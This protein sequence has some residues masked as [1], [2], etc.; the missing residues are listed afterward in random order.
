MK[1][2]H[3]RAWV[4]PQVLLSW[5]LHC[6]LIH[7]THHEGHLAQTWPH[8]TETTTAFRLTFMLI[9]PIVVSTMLLISYQDN[10]PV[11]CFNER[12]IYIENSGCKLTIFKEI[13]PSWHYLR[14]FRNIL[15]LFF[16]SAIRNHILWM[17]SLD[18]KEKYS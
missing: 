1:K 16:Y 8:M 18:P 14:S 10:P 11:N 7:I 4:W 13:C 17:R 15:S 2:L 3:V 5:S 9:D 6:V 12:L